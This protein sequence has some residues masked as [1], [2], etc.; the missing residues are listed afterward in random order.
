VLSPPFRPKAPG[1]RDILVASPPDGL[2]TLSSTALRATL[3]RRDEATVTAMVSS[4]ATALL[5]RP[6]V[7]EH[8]LFSSDYAKLKVEVVSGDLLAEC[9]WCC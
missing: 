6:S 7:E 5:L 3:E 1:Q 4:A 9:E 8:A 2:G